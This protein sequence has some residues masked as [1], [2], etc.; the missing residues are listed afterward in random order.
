MSGSVWLVVS[1]SSQFI[2]LPHCITI[3][4]QFSRHCITIRHQ[5]SRVFWWSSD[6]IV[7]SPEVS[8]QLLLHSFPNCFRTF[9]GVVFIESWRES[10]GEKS[11]LCLMSLIQQCNVWVRWMKGAW[12]VLVLWEC[13]DTHTF[14]FKFWYHLSFPGYVSTSPNWYMGP[15]GF[16]LSCSFLEKTR[17]SKM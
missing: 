13:W 7:F 15:W 3:I 17:T 16:V 2:C 12:G 6:L 11:Q 9:L 1:C 4:H 5:F 8:I 10:F 14:L